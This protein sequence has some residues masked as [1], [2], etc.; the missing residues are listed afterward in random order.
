MAARE[1]IQSIERAQAGMC[2]CVTI[3]SALKALNITRNIQIHVLYKIMLAFLSLDNR[4]I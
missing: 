1:S 4:G 3:I 2:K